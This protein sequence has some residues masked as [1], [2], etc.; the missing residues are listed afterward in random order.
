VSRIW[1]RRRATTAGFTL[2]EL[3]VVVVIVGVLAA[4]SAPYVAKERKATLGREIASEIARELQRARTQALSER[5][6]IRA[7]IYRDRVEIRSWVPGAN[8]G[9]PARAPT[10]TDP[11]LR[12][13][14]GQLKVD[15]LDVLATGSPPPG[16]QVLTSSSAVQIDFTAQGQM[17]FIGQAPL[18]P[19]FVFIQNSN[20]RSNHPDAFFRID[21]TSLTGHVA[22]RSGWN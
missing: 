10:T 19:A 15:T 22:L 7:F 8:P 14:N 13:I 17:Q 16:S 9:D 5:L 18:T 1:Q 12:S 6:S 21:I 2:T 4:L 20:V 11:L 3:M